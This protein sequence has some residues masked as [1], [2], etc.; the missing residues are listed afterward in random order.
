MS[1][2]DF[3]D[4]PVGGYAP[5][6]RDVCQVLKT[7]LDTILPNDPHGFYVADRTRDGRPELN[8]WLPTE[9]KRRRGVCLAA[10]HGRGRFWFTKGSHPRVGIGHVAISYSM[11]AGG[12][13]WTETGYL[14]FDPDLPWL[15]NRLVIKRYSGITREELDALVSIAERVSWGRPV[16][17]PVAPEIQ[18]PDCGSRDDPGTPNR[19]PRPLKPG[20]VPE[21]R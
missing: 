5:Q 12:R 21:A 16:P 9:H 18:C 13:T 4:A 3:D 6:E 15:P 17:S 1:A 7:H 19:S 20:H 2:D 14:S 11:T 10:A 8:E